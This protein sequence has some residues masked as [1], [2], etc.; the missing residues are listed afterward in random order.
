[1]NTLRSMTPRQ[2]LLS[3]VHNAP[4]DRTPVGS[5][6]S[7]ANLEQMEMT[8]AYFPDVHLSGPLMAR[9]AAGAHTILGYDVIMPVFSVTVEA[10][11]LGAEIDWG[12]RETMPACLNAPWEDPAQVR[13][14][15]DLL[16][17]EPTRAV[18][19]AIRL[20]R[21]EYGGRV[22]IAGKVMGPWTLAYHMHGVQAFLL[23]TL[24]DPGR[25]RAFLQALE[26]VTV[27][28]GRAQL[29]AGA[30]LLC[31]ADHATGDLIS[32][33]M[34]REFLLP[35][36]REITRQLRCPTVLHICGNTLD[37]MD[38]IAGSGFDCFHFE[39]RVDAR[40]AVARVAGRISLMGNVNNPEVLLHGTPEQVA[41]QARY[42]RDAGVR[43]VGPECA[44]P[45]AT[46][47]ANLRAIAEAVAEP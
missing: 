21:A 42:A 10:A 4:V 1:M 35:H 3:A 17:R 15:S 14:P 29:Q 20:L 2:R 32:P 39:S 26:P 47:T 13:I 24:T 27:Q 16:D 45:L 22:A 28:F 19:E 23:E 25:V 36:H 7:V 30:D 9:L 34:Y 38:D 8:G 18:L 37:R 43:I 40:A 41:A 31:V 12:E 46:P 33:R 11:A 44:V 6:T 5:V